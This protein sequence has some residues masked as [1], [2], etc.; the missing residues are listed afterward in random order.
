MTEAYAIVHELFVWAGRGGRRE[1][2]EDK[3]E[4]HALEQRAY[5]TAAKLDLI[6]MTKESRTLREYMSVA[7]EHASTRPGGENLLAKYEETLTA[8]KN[9]VDG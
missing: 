6:G 8:L 7:A 1:R 3:D 5:T 4:R 9:A 2:V